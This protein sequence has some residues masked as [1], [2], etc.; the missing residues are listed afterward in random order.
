[1]LS[2]REEQPFRRDFCEG[3]WEDN[4]QSQMT[5][6]EEPISRWQSTVR[7]SPPQPKEEAIKRSLAEQLLRKYLDFSE[8]RHVNFCYILG[9]MLERR[10]VL[11]EKHTIEEDPSGKTIIVY[12]HART[13]ESF[14][15]EDPHLSLSLISEVQEQVKE[16]L[17][18]EQEAREA[19]EKQEDQ[20][21]STPGEN[22][23]QE[24]V[25]P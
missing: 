5:E 17:D 18:S 23:I 1:M 9:L 16:I 12:E 10:R 15:I 8:R 7:I 14:L 6:G 3:C 25:E 20:E 4:P 24:E 22:R 11:S 2:Y 13:G 19:E 21:P